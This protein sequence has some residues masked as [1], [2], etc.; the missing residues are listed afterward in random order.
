MSDINKNKQ[1]FYI[2]IKETVEKLRA[3][4]DELERGIV[5]IN[6]NECLIAPDKQVKISLKAKGNKFSTKLEFKLATPFVDRE[7][8]I[9]IKSEKDGESE[10]SVLTD[11]GVGKY[12]NLKKRMSKDFKAIKKSCTEEQTMPE[13]DLLERF[14]QDSKTMC[15]YLNKGEEFYE[16]Y[17]VQVGLLYEAFK[18]SDLIAMKSTIE[19]LRQIRDDCH[20]RHK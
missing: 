6:D 11:Y 20:D 8:K 5:T 1:D 14:Y 16:R 13:S 7:D 15:T 2:P 12:K 4:A 18:A 9:F 19:S 17:L 10:Y 3:L